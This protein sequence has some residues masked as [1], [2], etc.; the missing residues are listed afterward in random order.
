VMSNYLDLGYKASHTPPGARLSR[1][2][3]T[4]RGG[5]FESVTAS[6]KE[7]REQQRDMLLIVQLRGIRGVPERCILSL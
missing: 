3:G 4:P 6:W 5:R 7:E 1:F 2:G